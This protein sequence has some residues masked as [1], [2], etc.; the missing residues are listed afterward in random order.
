MTRK[1]PRCRLYIM[2]SAIRYVFFVYKW[3]DA[4]CVIHVLLCG[5]CVVGALRDVCYVFLCGF[6]DVW[7]AFAR[8][9]TVL[10]RASVVWVMNALVWE[11]SSSLSLVNCLLLYRWIWYECVCVC[12]VVCAWKCKLFV[13]KLTWAIEC[14][15]AVDRKAN[16]SSLATV[17]LADLV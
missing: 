6:A 9:V 16:E 2:V 8:E 5:I 1:R 17:G 15:S 11:L 3:R 4:Q 12:G 13:L 10:L 14:V 7:L